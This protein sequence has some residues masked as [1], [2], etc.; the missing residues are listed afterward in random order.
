MDDIPESKR[1]KGHPFHWIVNPTD[2]MKL[3]PT[4][5][6]HVPDSFVTFVRVAPA[7]APAMTAINHSIGRQK[8][9]SG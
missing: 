4:C 6:R 7:P 1:R 2:W 8:P 3:D 9:F 5:S